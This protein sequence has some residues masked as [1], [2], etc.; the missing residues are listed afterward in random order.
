M[1]EIEQT[2][3]ETNDNDF[4]FYLKRDKRG[5]DDK[6]IPYN[7]YCIT[8]M[9][10][11]IYIFIVS[12]YLNRNSLTSPG[13]IV[14]VQLLGKTN[15]PPLF[16]LV[17]NVICFCIACISDIIS[18]R[19]SFGLWLLKISNQSCN[20]WWRGSIRQVVIAS[21]ICSLQRSTIIKESP[22]SFSW[23]DICDWTRILWQAF[24][25]RNIYNYF[26]YLS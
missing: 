17:Q 11:I 12:I 19:F 26:H 24:S 21:L 5:R 1:I 18:E 20:I 2:E 8:E 23:L 16:L 25:L 9:S 22:G 15:G 13:I 4:R 3:S 14:L 6:W 10:K 7:N